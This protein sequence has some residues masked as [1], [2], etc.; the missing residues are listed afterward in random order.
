M[1]GER[2]ILF[3]RYYLYWLLFFVVQKPIFMLWQHRLMGD[4]TLGDYFRVIVHA[5]PLDLSVASYVMLVMGLILIAGCWIPQRAIRIATDALT[6]IVLVVG[7]FVMIGDNGCFPSWGIRRCL[8]FSLHLKTLWQVRRGGCGCWGH[9]LLRCSLPDG[10]G[11][12]GGTYSQKTARRQRMNI[13]QYA[14]V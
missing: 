7:L 1:S 2:I 9:W 4:I 11:S 14:V 12:T 8:F 13:N 10:G 3:I 6:A 5:F